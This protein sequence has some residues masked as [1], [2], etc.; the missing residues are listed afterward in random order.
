MRNKKVIICLIAA[1]FIEFIISNYSIIYNNL[2]FSPDSLTLQMSSYIQKDLKIIENETLQTLSNDSYFIIT[3][4]NRKIS[5]I[6]LEAIDLSDEKNNIQIYFSNNRGEFTEENSYSLKINQEDMRLFK[7]APYVKDLRI[8]ISNKP[9][10]YMRIS[11]ITLNPKL[12]FSMLWHRVILILI[13]L[14]FVLNYKQSDKIEMIKR[15]ILS[16]SFYAFINYIL[17]YTN[18][19]IGNDKLKVIGIVICF[20]IYILMLLYNRRLKSITCLAISY[21]AVFGL[22]FSVITPVFQVP[23]EYVHFYRAYNLSL[24]KINLEDLNGELGGLLPHSISK[25]D[26]F[27][28]VNKLPFNYDE[29]VDLDTY[30]DIYSIPLDEEIVSHYNFTATRQYGPTSYIPQAV[31]I[32]FARLLGL[33]PAYMIVLGRLFNL[34]VYIC[35][36]YLAL[37]IV[38]YGNENIIAVATVPMSIYLG[39]SNSPDAILISLSLLYVSYVLDIIVNKKRLTFMNIGITTLMLSIISL[40]KLPYILLGGLLFLA[41]NTQDHKTKQILKILVSYLL[42]LSIVIIW[43][44]FISKKYETESTEITV[45][46]RI[47]QDPYKFIQSIINSLV[48]YKEHYRVSMIAKFGWLD[49]PLPTNIVDLYYLLV[50]SISFIFSNDKSEISTF[51]RLWMILIF[52]GMSCSIFLGSMAWNIGDTIIHGVQGRYFLPFIVLLLFGARKKFKNDS[53]IMLFDISNMILSSSILLIF[54]RYYI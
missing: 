13:L 1:I 24:G 38:P 37:K 48:F 3:D 47:A 39:A 50:I 35:L 16:V 51:D 2:F 11:K 33:G 49:T 43:K 12:S 15:I 26:E 46:S 9:N 34:A 22:L 45:I 27:G 32:A 4:M 53:Y 8:D 52:I 20:L 31:G 18:Q 17:T 10:Q 25:I 21:I 36:I 5:S 6:K 19:F 7:H 30:F 29:K 23:D 40:I 41:F 44:R 42:T 14:W 28:N 54:C